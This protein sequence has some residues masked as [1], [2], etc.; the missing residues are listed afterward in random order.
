MTRAQFET[1]IAAMEQAG[2]DHTRIFASFANGR[3]I[4][5]EWGYVNEVNAP[6]VGLIVIGAIYIDLACVLFIGPGV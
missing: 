1:A 3:T 4:T 5:G 2:H 6:S